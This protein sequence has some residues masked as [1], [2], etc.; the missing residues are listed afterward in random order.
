MNKC[1]WCLKPIPNNKDFCN[2]GHSISY[3]LSKKRPNIIRAFWDKVKKTDNIGDCW[4]WDSHKNQKGY[5]RFKYNNKRY[6]AH[7]MAFELQNGE[8]KG[9]LHVLHTCDNPSCCNPTHLFLG[10]NM[11]N[12]QD[13]MNKNRRPRGEYSGRAKL[14]ENQ[15]Y[16][17]LFLLKYGYPVRKIKDLYMVTIGAIYGIKNNQNWNHLER[18]I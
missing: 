10:T 8:I 4:V 15:V 14:K 2:R 12:I 1:K 3:T 18:L 5:G 11:D 9:G 6:T 13:S 16:E 7:R 17:I